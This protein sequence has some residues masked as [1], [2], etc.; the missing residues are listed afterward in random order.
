MNI[1]QVLA[2]HKLWLKSKGGQRADL[3]GVDLQGAYLQGADLRAAYLQGADLQRADLRGADLRG[4][5]LRGAYLRGAKYKIGDKEIEIGKVICQIQEKYA[6]TIF[7][8]LIKIGCQEHEP[9]RWFKFSDE[10]IAKMG[11]G[12]LDW[13]KV[14]K[15]IIKK[16]WTNGEKGGLV[17]KWTNKQR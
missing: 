12:A 13:W 7:D 14:W 8:T 16:I 11:S 3:R 10:L 6:I 5:D 4:V 17:I 1:S 15:P 9:A 2:D